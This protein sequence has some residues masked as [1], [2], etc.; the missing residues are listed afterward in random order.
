[1]SVKS[2]KIK[3]LLR[4]FGAN[5]VQRAV[6]NLGATRTINGRKRRWVGGNRKGGNSLIDN[7]TYNTAFAEKSGRITMKFFAKGPAKQYAD[8][9]EFGRRPYP[10]QWKHA[11]P[12]Q[13]I[14]DWI[15][16]KN[17]RPR[18]KG[19]G[20]I[21]PSTPS[22]LNRMNYNI[23]KSI[24]EKGIPGVFFFTDAIR[25]ELDE[26]GQALAKQLVD[27]MMVFELPKD[28]RG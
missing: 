19:T 13:A 10:G 28:E 20:K 7:L 21:L 22:N 12:K 23:R 9:V 16:T 2:E 8:V 24:L 25:D 6:G 27:T 4:E 26:N 1:M 15:K 3:A 17:I 11:P 14:S 18:E 5:V